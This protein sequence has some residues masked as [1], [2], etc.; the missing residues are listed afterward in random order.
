M[1]SL[2]EKFAVFRLR[3]MSFFYR[4]LGRYQ[5]AIDYLQKITQTAHASDRDWWHLGLLLSQLE[6]WEEAA[7]SFQKAVQISRRKAQYLYW[8]GTAQENLGNTAE[9]E[10]LYDEA[11][12][13]NYGTALAAKGHILMK[14][15]IY[16]EALELFREYLK[17]SPKD[18]EVLN[19]AGLCFFYLGDTDK[20]GHYL[21][22][23]LAL[24]PRDQTISHNLG[25]TYIRQ[26]KYP[27]ALQIYENMDQH[28]DK[29][30]CKSM[31][32]CYGCVE[33]WEESLQYY[34]KALEVDP[35]DPE[36]KLNM[37]SIYAK[38]GEST[39]ALEILK[40]LLLSNPQDT[41][42]LNNLAWT[43]ENLQLLEEAEHNYWRSLALSPGNPY[44]I[45]NLACCLK[46]QEKY[47][48]AIDI[49]EHLGKM[50]GWQKIAWTTIAQIYEGLEAKSLA[51]D[52][53]NKAL[54][55]E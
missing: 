8:L 3:N 1:L 16:E 36:T 28:H 52:Y 39:R 24:K 2:K 54:G 10:V 46:K 31:A 7:Q 40:D 29:E 14:K 42:I 35:D 11:V 5:V 50:K 6:R 4:L 30:I 17:T 37:A 48:E 38:N 9:A 22:Q 53:Y 44:V 49:L 33:K 51:V 23:A 55:L 20:A 27:E 26:Q 25:L 15:E 43:Y 32:F 34:R 13:G 18:T 45:Y 47:L 12:L 19:A 41:D 21:G